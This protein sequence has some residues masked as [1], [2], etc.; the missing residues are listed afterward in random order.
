MTIGNKNIKNF[1]S[2]FN[3]GFD[4]LIIISYIQER[5]NN[6][7]NDDINDIV[8]VIRMA[9][10]GSTIKDDDS[11]NQKIL[12]LQKLAD[13]I[14]E[15]IEGARGF[16]FNYS[17]MKIYQDIMLLVKGSILDEIDA[18][19]SPNVKPEK[20]TD[21]KNILVQ[22]SKYNAPQIAYILHLLQKRNILIR[23]K[24]PLTDYIEQ[25]LPNK[26]EGIRKKMSNP[27]DISKNDFDALISLM[28]DI[29]SEM[30]EFKSNNFKK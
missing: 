14:D 3:N 4:N 27:D 26:G 25:Y 8:R 12:L 24:K 5:G 1:N 18:L 10:I 20:V 21:N 9:Y 7:S 15:S 13:N 22:P 17:T 28:K 23:D 16:S 29:L 6:F 19:E 11:K 2:L 30:E